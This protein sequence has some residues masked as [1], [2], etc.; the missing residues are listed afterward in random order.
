METHLQ[1]EVEVRLGSHEE[2]RY[3]VETVLL[4]CAV[5]GTIKPQ[6]CSLEETRRTRRLLMYEKEFVSLESCTY[7]MTSAR[8]VFLGFRSVSAS[9]FDP[10]SCSCTPSVNCCDDRD[11]RDTHH[12]VFFRPI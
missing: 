12:E 8:S 3:V 4:L 10:N 7:T 6:R 2:C 11:R 5:G 1:R 9:Y